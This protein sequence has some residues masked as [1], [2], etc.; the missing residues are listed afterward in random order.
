MTLLDIRENNDLN[1]I[2]RYVRKRLWNLFEFIYVRVDDKGEWEIIPVDDSSYEKLPEQ[3][4]R[5]ERRAVNQ[6]WVA[7]ALWEAS[8]AW[9]A[10]ANWS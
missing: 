3:S 1:K 2:T 7:H 10:A 5:C 9:S 8:S 4:S 6:W